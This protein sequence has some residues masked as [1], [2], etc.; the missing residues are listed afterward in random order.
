M[1][2]ARTAQAAAIIP[3]PSGGPQEDAA[4]APDPDKLKVV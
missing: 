1:D 2:N 4:S 3:V